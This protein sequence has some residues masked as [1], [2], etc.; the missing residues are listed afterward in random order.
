MPGKVL[1]GWFYPKLESL[2]RALDSRDICFT[3]LSLHNENW[4][5][6][7][8]HRRIKKWTEGDWVHSVVVFISDRTH[9][10][11]VD[12]DLEA[13]GGPQVMSLPCVLGMPAMEK[14]GMLADTR[15]PE[16]IVWRPEDS[17]SWSGDILWIGGEAYGKMASFLEFARRVEVDLAKF[18]PP[19]LAVAE[20]TR[21]YFC[22]IRKRVVLHAGCV[23]GAPFFVHSVSHRKIRHHKG[24]LMETM[25]GDLVREEEMPADELLARH[26]ALM[27]SLTGKAEYRWYPE[28]ESLTLNDRHFTKGVPAKILK[29]LLEDY[30]KAGKREF[31]YRDFKRRFEISLGQKNSNFEVRFTRLAE[32][33]DAEPGGLRIEKTGRG[34]FRL[35]VTGD[36]ALS[37]G[38]V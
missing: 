14:F 23:Y 5:P 15:H 19:D 26:Q 8:L 10:E 36:L 11:Y 9:Q 35:L 38:S 13:I 27:A 4:I 30:L 6:G 3:L 24:A 33:L 1:L 7:L 16:A 37:E 25:I 32:K 31:E 18:D 2:S 17:P 21:D 34:R 12:W 29:G 22:P 28:D 20:M